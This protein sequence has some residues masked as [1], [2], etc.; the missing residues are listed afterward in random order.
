MFMSDNQRDPQYKLR[1]SEELRDKIQSSAK[2]H[3]RSINAEIIYRL[4]K[5]FEF[6]DESSLLG[7]HSVNKALI[8]TLGRKQPVANNQSERRRLAQLAAWAVMQA[9]ENDQSEDDKKAP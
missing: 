3:N 4:E 8:P 5:S 7:V 1:W 9:L 6:N 2:E